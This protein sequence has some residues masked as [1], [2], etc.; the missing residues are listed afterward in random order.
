MNIMLAALAVTT[1]ISITAYL[2]LDEI[3]KAE[4]EKSS[5]K[6]AKEILQKTKNAVNLSQLNK[7]VS[8]KQ[9]DMV[10]GNS[11]YYNK[12]IT[13]KIIET[14][15]IDESAINKYALAVK[16]L[17]DQ[18]GNA[19]IDCD[20]LSLTKIITMDE[21]LKVHNKQFSF[22]EFDKP[23]KSLDLQISNPA[24]NAKVLSM[25]KNQNLIPQDDSN[26][27]IPSSKLE[28][29]RTIIA[30]KIIANETS[31]IERTNELI[32]ASQYAH[33]TNTISKSAILSVATQ[34]NLNKLEQ[35]NSS[36]LNKIDA[37]S[38]V[39]KKTELQDELEKIQ[40][41]TIE[42]IAKSSNLG[43]TTNLKLGE[44]SKQ[45]L[46]ST[47]PTVLEKVNQSTLEIYN[48]RITNLIN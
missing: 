12:P 6:D 24:T 8:Q 42:T 46:Q 27:S 31:D 9:E 13:Q 26:I 34:Q 7:A 22:L 39:T 30:R 40:I 10:S 25:A 20:A 21:C 3:K 17:L 36:L 18:N 33:A 38:N 23:T 29:G 15:N 45:I 48:S 1:T 28:K 47:T 37:E 19:T 11:F 35:I 16:Q 41:M 32:E 44:A 14:K 5:T 43:S 4:T 2:A